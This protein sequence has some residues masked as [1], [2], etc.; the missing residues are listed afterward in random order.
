MNPRV[1]TFLIPFIVVDTLFLAAI[2]V[3]V[4]NQQQHHGSIG[5]GKP[6]IHINLRHP[7]AKLTEID[8]TNTGNAPGPLAVAV[9]VTW[10]DADLVDA[11]GLSQFDAMDTGRRSLRFQPQ[12]SLHDATLPPGQPFAIG[13]LKLTDDV[14]VHAEIVTDVSSATQP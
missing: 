10:P 13:W 5:L 8:L 3:W 4:F 1:K 12:P 14:P 11:K 2:L 6:D 9:D 7:E